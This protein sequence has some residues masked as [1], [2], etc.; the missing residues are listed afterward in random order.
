MYHFLK[1]KKEAFDYY[2]Y[3]INLDSGNL[4]AINNQGLLLYEN[5]LYEKSIPYFKKAIKAS[6]THPE[7]YH[8]MGV[9]LRDY[10]KD[11][12]MSKYYLKKAFFLDPEY[13]LN[14]YQLG[15]TYKALNNIEEAKKMFT[16]CLE[17]SP[18]YTDAEKEL[19]KIRD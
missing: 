1:N 12:E 16:R 7:A 11:Y 9:V 13:P 3:A 14:S 4:S 10:C 19:N 8:H 18:S 2:A 15:L 6:P 17:L 5:K